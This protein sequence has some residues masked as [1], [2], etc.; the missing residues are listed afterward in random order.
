MVGIEIEMMPFL[1]KSLEQGQRPALIHLHGPQSLSTFLSELAASEGWTTKVVSD[2]PSS[3][4]PTDALMSVILERGDNLSFEP[5]G[6][7]EISSI[8]YPCLS[9]ALE[10]VT[11]VQKKLDA[12]LGAHGVELLQSGINPW[13]TVDELDLQ[14]QKPR[15]QAM[16]TYFQRIGTFG[17]RMM[18]QTCTVQV[19]LDFG[20][21]EITLAKRYVLANLL[22]PFATAIFAYSPYVNNALSGMKSARAEAWRNIDPSRTGIPPLD[23]IIKKFDKASCVETYLDFV[24]DAPVVFV[25]RDGYSVPAQDFTFRRWLNES[26]NGVSPTMEDFETHLSLHFPEVRPRGFL[27][28]RSVDCQARVWQSVP[29]LFY[30]SLL[31]VPSVLDK[32]LERLLPLAGDIQALLLNS[33]REGLSN[34]IIRNES[35]WL[36]QL[37]EDGLA[38]LTDCFR[39]ESSEQ[40]FRAFMDHFTRQ[41]RCPADDLIDQIETQPDR[42]LLPGTFRQL[43]KNW[44]RL[45]K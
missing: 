3:G 30:I 36:M 43:E 6:Q 37:V 29:A 7:L 39:G 45:I 23:K 18:R 2:T 9:D 24:L 20:G 26:I 4:K 8:P 31:Y 42:K 44:L 34:K 41:G 27:E 21:D 13:Q 17:R 38:C 16:D 19:N 25:A 33:G 5:G 35:V 1:S 15:Y 22:A 10:R 14:M 28:L 32:A 11:A 40:S 12:A